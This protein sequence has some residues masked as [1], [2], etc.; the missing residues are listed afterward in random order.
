[1][2]GETQLSKVPKS[3]EVRPPIPGYEI[4]HTLGQGGT[5]SV[6]RAIQAKTGRPLALK[7]LTLKHAQ[8]LGAALARLE[9]EA[10]I[11]RSLDHP[12][13]VSVVDYGH[14]KDTAWIAM[15]LLDGFELTHALTDPSFGLKDRLNV[16]LRV[17][18]ALQ[19]AH[20]LGIVHR[21]V[22]PSNIFMTRD[23][24]VRLLDF[25]IA[26]IKVAVRGP[27]LAGRDYRSPDYRS[28]N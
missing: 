11:G 12:D 23:G 24:G 22:K 17:A 8:D 28:R 26:H 14:S 13:I 19:Y 5:A 2:A 4:E 7:V 3:K 1:M 20:E 15:D 9:R 25:G 6:Y 10:Q 18:A 16:V 21:D 27:T